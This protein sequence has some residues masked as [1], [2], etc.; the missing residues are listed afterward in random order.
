MGLQLSLSTEND[1]INT[2]QVYHSETIDFGFD[3]TCKLVP[4]VALRNELKG[5][6]KFKFSSW[7]EIASIAFH[8][9][10]HEIRKIQRQ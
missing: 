3:K 4:S 8:L 5:N 7:V 10:S 2:P 6:F 1:S 9:F